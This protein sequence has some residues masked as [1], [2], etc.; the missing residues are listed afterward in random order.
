MLEE[1]TGLG[2]RS[3]GAGMKDAERFENSVDRGR[4]DGIEE[5]EDL[6]GE[7][8]ELG[9]VGGDPFWEDGLEAL[10][11]WQVSEEPDLLKRLQ[12]LGLGVF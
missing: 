6:G 9:L 11:T 4:R 8:S 12:D 7:K 10:G 2:G 1:K 3:S 5:I